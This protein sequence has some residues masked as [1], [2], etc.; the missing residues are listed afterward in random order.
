MD[1]ETQRRE[2][3]PEFT[4][5]DLNTLLAK[6]NDDLQIKFQIDTHPHN[7][8]FEHLISQS[9]FGLILKYENYVL[10]EESWEAPYLLQAKRLFRYSS[11]LGYDER[12]RFQ[13]TNPNQQKLLER[14]CEVFGQESFRYFLY[15]PPISLLD[16]QVSI[17][18]RAL[19]NRNLAGDIFDFARGLSLFGHLQERSGHIE[20]GI[21]LTPIAMVPSTLLNLHDNAFRGAS[22]FSWFVIDHFVNGRRSPRTMSPPQV[23]RSQ[24]SP[25][26]LIA[27]VTRGERRAIE[28]F[29]RRA[30]GPRETALPEIV[31]LPSFTITIEVSVGASLSPETRRAFQA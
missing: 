1:A 19:H 24:Q 4:I 8:V 3:R 5:D 14:L 31:I 2:R 17:K 18:I 21:W 11:T 23:R 6:A 16:N 15:T 28:E 27:D 29:I 10:P 13:S 20:S 12:A 26:S 7:S 9:D 25:A 30:Y 22:P